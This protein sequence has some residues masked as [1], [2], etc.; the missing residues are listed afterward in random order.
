MLYIYYLHSAAWT[1]MVT[2]TL[3]G[4]VATYGK[5]YSAICT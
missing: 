1:I 2:N 5:S 3:K 4:I